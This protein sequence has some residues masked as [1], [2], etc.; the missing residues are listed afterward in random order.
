MNRE[1]RQFIKGLV[2]LSPWLIGFLVFTLL[3]IALSLYFSLC[4]FDMLQPPVFVGVRNYTALAHDA[5]FWQTI[6]NTFYYAAMALP[7]G[8]V[9]SLGL[10]M[11][12]NIE[13]P[14]RAI[15]RTIVFMP[16]LVPI[17]ASAI[18]WMWLLNPRLGLINMILVKLHI[19]PPPW[20]SDPRWAM[21]A[22]ALM[23]LWGVGN[24]VVIFLAG[25]QDVP[26]DLCEAAELDGA[27]IMGRVWHI[28]LPMLSP[29]IFFNLVV[30]II[31]TLQVFDVPYIMTNGGPVRST[32]FLSMYLYDKAFVY[33]QMGYAGAMAWI[34]LL[35]ILALTGLAFWTSR[36]WVHYQGR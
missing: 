6:R 16:S 9:L 1:L 30:A 15:W 5:V 10:A 27:G 20:L 24:A 7:A 25:L 4:K 32:Y 35:I 33:L 13:M 18:V 17:V 14:G 36:H 11:L 31:G 21:P 8:L 3:P 12:L 19:P 23:S 34:M 22:L 2:F 29:V 26:L 28:T